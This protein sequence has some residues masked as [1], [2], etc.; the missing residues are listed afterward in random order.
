MDIKVCARLRARPVRNARVRET[1]RTTTERVVEVRGLR[2]RYEVIAVDG[3]DLDIRQGEAFGIP[4]P[5]RAGKSTTAE[6]LQGHRSRGE[7]T[8]SVLGVAPASA[9]RRR[10]SRVG[11]VWQDESPPAELTL[12]ETVTH[13]ARYHPRPRDCEHVIALVGPARSC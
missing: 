7:G 10:R 1:L 8:V 13:F 11:T 4:G 3:L 6:I 12:C 2:K 9:D 5:S